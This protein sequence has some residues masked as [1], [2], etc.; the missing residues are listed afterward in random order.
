[1]ENNVVLNSKDIFS[2]A[3]TGAKK[4]F[5]NFFIV[6]VCFMVL[7]VINPNKPGESLGFLRSIISTIGSVYL[8][9]SLY[10]AVFKI[11]NGQEVV[12]KDF[13]AW[14]KNGFKM[15]WSGIV[16]G[17]LI[18]PIFILG[19]VIAGVLGLIGAFSNAMPFVYAVIGLIVIVPSVY[20]S[21]R[22]MLAKYHALLNGSGVVDS[23]KESIKMTKG[24]VLRIIWL[25]VI[26]IGIAIL[27]A[28]ALVIGLFWAIPTIII[29][30][31]LIYKTLSGDVSN[32]GNITNNVLPEVQPLELQANMP[33]AHNGDSAQN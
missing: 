6:L 10:S 8:S 2:F 3:F 20:I 33:E 15:L 26:M 27:G 5:K 23:I 22:V 18:V 4:N 32:S 14:P 11:V 29:A 13:F 7:E 1:M 21:T 19:L 31:V 24:K 16:S 9:I 17:L 12:L 25:Y 28:L 30:Q